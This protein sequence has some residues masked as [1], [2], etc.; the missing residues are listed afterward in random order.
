MLTLAIL[1]P[2][3]HFGWFQDG[4]REKIQNAYNISL[5]PFA[6]FTFMS[7]PFIFKIR[8][9]ISVIKKAKYVVITY[10]F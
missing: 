2:I 1:G 7:V 9:S 4:R 8:N 3:R 6:M 5:L 10:F